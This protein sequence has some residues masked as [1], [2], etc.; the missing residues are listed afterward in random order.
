MPTWVGAWSPI[1]GGEHSHGD[2]F[3][4]RVRVVNVVS[5]RVGA[6][7]RVRL[8]PG[9]GSSQSWQMVAATTIAAT[10]IVVSSSTVVALAVVLAIEI[11]SWIARWRTRCLWLRRSA[12]RG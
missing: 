11:E 4:E 7:V 1:L 12:G 2:S 3:T 8:A 9:R 6:S 5:A 10:A